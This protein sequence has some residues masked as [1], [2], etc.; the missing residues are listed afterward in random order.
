MIA[1]LLMA[2]LAAA[3][4]T[5]DS[6]AAMERLKGLVGS[7]ESTTNDSSTPRPV[8]YSITGGGKVLVEETGGMMTAY[9]MDKERLVLTHFCGAGNQP[10]MRIT[11]AD[12]HHIAFEMYDITNLSDSEAYHSTSLDV[13]FVGK[14]RVDLVYGGK[15]AGRS[16]TQV[17]HL[18]RKGK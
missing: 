3:H 11:A 2:S 9:H 16:T 1:L 4:S 7:W 18:T 12:D 10:R 5:P 14:D 13:V 8:T 15:T 6:G 17:F